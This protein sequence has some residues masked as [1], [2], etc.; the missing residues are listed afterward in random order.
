MTS[1][2]K[3]SVESA[4]GAGD[5]GGTAAIDD[6]ILI[7]VD[8]RQGG[9]LASVDEAM[10][11]PVPSGSF[12]KAVAKLGPVARAVLAQVKGLGLSEVQIELGIKFAADVGIILAKSSGE[13]TCKVSI[14][15]KMSEEKPRNSE[16]AG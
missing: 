14:G 13:A 10:G 15:W 1:Y 6:F 7:E 11:S 9:G 3:M 5:A 4:D 12:E 2:L 8:D 16:N